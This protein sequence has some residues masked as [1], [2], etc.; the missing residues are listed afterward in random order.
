MP[1]EPTLQDEDWQ[2]FWDSVNGG[3]LE[4]NRVR[5][6]RQEEV[7]WVRKSD[8]FGAVPRPEATHTPI[9]LKWVDTNKG[10]GLNP[11]YRSRLV[12]RDIKARKKESE[13][14]PMK[15]LFSSMPP[16]EAIRL[17]VSI[18]MSQRVNRLGRRLKLAGYDISR[19]HFNAE[20]NREVFAELPEE[21]RADFPGQDVVARLKKSWYGLQDASSLWQGDYSKLLVENGFAKGKSNGAVFYQEA[22]GCSLLVHG[23]GFLVLGD[24]TALETFEAMLGSRYSFKKLFRL[25][26]DKEDD[27]TGTFLNRII[28]IDSSHRPH[29]AMV[30]PDARHAQLLVEELGLQRETGAET[31]AEARTAEKQQADAKTAKLGDSDKKLYRSCVMR[32]AYLAQD[33]PRIAEAI[34]GLARHMQSPTEADFQRLKRLGRFLKKHPHV[35]AVYPEQALPDTLHVFVDS[36]HAGC[37]LTRRSTT[38]LAMMLGTHCLKHGSNLQS[39]ISLSSG[40]SEWYAIVKGAATG[41]FMRSLLRDLGCELQLRNHSDSSAARGFSQRQGLGRLRHVQTR[42]LWVQERVKEGH[43]EVVPVRGKNNTAD[44]FP[45]AVSGKLRDRYLQRLGYRHAKVGGLQKRILTDSRV[46]PRVGVG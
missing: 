18:L 14:M 9:D 4:T 44:M 21:L 34:K 28:S 3:Y 38:G 29:R 2:E 23:D 13:K 1:A 25:G 35:Q 8:L 46:A 22:Q 27:K 7:D 10:D 45:K 16:L 39:T 30:E 32:G 31:P 41:L 12:L 17:F 43:L 6:A 15:D 11:N 40:E 26:V 20:L 5:A 19:A 37:G 42:F 33:D 36:D 24:D